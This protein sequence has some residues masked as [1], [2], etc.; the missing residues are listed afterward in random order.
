MTEALPPASLSVPP[1]CAPAAWTLA[2]GPL[3]LSTHPGAALRFSASPVRSLGACAAVASATSVR[4][5]VF[6][7]RGH[8][9]RP[10]LG[11]VTLRAEGQTPPGPGPSLSPT[12][13]ELSVNK[14]RTSKYAFWDVNFKRLIKSLG[15]SPHLP[16]GLGWETAS[17][18]GA[19][20]GVT[21]QLSVG[22]GMDSGASAAYPL[23]PA[24][25]DSLARIC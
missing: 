13:R 22:T 5:G 12:F 18:E 15:P 24:V 3:A 17:A 21:A 20:P 11:A 2:E 1:R 9:E 10:A 16:E 14:V 4:G 6:P 8:R 19:S 25:S 23:W 7:P